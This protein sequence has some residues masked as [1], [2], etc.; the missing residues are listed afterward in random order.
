MNYKE[1]KREIEERT[2]AIE[3]QLGNMDLKLL[4]ELLNERTLYIRDLLESGTDRDE[5]AEVLVA[6][7]GRDAL[8]RTRLS[9]IKSE[10]LIRIET[11]KRQKE[12]RSKYLQS[13]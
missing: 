4:S 3:R 10:L 2:S 11:Q 13:F 9:L 12:A 7:R 6:I 1:I 8:I 5:M